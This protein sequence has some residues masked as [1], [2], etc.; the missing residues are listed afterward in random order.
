MS[1]PGSLLLSSIT[2]TRRAT[3][4]D[5]GTLQPTETVS[6]VASAVPARLEP[7]TGS[8]LNTVIGRLPDA[9]HLLFTNDFDL[10]QDDRVVDENSVKY[11]VRE[12]KSLPGL[13]KGHHIEAILEVV[14]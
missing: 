9:S 10:K 2:V 6:T 8:I 12:V 4:I 7:L 1:L 11:R 14:T 13:F 3:S 5:A